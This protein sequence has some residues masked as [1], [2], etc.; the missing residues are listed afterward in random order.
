VEKPTP[1][2]ISS[3]KA[4][5]LK[6]KKL[7]FSPHVVAETN[8]FRRPFIGSTA[9]QHVPMEDDATE[10]SAQQKEKAQPSKQHIEIID[11][12]TP[13][14]DNNPTFKR[15]RSIHDFRG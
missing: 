2:E 10:A 4:R 1:M 14:H 11:I 13:P 8:K 9:K 5:S 12:N 15:L 6:G 3:G 7:I